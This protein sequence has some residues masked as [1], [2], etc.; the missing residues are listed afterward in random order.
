MSST[1]LL[2]R[3]LP[4][5]ICIGNRSSVAQAMFLMNYN[6]C[7]A[8]VVLSS[9]RGRK[10]DPIESVNEQLSGIVTR[11]DVFKTVVE[12]VASMKIT[13]VGRIMTPSY[14]VITVSTEDEVYSCLARMLEKSSTSLG[15]AR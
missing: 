14:E 3:V 1:R 9:A 2:R 12:N 6:N 13:K 5:R 10:L 15:S 11:T 8:L 4:T 7:D